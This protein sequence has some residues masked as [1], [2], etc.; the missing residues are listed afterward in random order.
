MTPRSILAVLALPLALAT[1]NMGSD[2]AM[3]L[4]D[5]NGAEEEIEEP[6]LCPKRLYLWHEHG[7]DGGTKSGSGSRLISDW[8]S[9]IILVHYQCYVKAGTWSPQYFVRS[10]RYVAECAGSGAVMRFTV[11]T[12]LS[13]EFVKTNGIEECEAE[14]DYEDLKPEWKLDVIP[15]VTFIPGQ[16]WWAVESGAKIYKL[17]PV[18]VVWLIKDSN[19]TDIPAEDKYLL[20]AG[21]GFTL[22]FGLK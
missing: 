1:R 16:S 9:K 18:G 22:G 2:R 17:P 12:K 15:E 19:V 11:Y 14:E 7:Q 20:S 4:Q 10:G 6:K 21:H 13:K 5:A 3:D 8:R